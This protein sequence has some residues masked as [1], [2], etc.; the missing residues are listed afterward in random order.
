MRGLINRWR[1]GSGAANGLL[2]RTGRYPEIA[3]AHIVTWSDRRVGHGVVIT[4]RALCWG[5]DLAA[6]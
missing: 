2:H 1:I 6:P 4:P 3:R 5:R